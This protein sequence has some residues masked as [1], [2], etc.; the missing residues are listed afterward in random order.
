[1]PKQTLKAPLFFHPTAGV[2]QSQSTHLGSDKGKWRERCVPL[3]S[4]QFPAVCPQ[5]AIADSLATL[6][7]RPKRAIVEEH[8]AS[9]PLTLL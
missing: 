1:M 9:E 6:L 5:R 2:L 8:V 7:T 4:D 3:I